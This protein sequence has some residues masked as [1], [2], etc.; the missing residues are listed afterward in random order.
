MKNILFV[1]LSAAIL[2]GCKPSTSAPVQTQ[3]SMTPPVEIN[4]QAATPTSYRY[5]L[6]EQNE[7][8]AP[9]PANIHVGHCPSPGAVQYPLVN[10]V[11]GKSTS[12]LDVSMEDILASA[13]ELSVNVHKSAAESK[14]YTAC[15]DIQ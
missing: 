4:N 8:T 3:P 11:N 9:Q 15:A 1:A 6:T 10:V 12:E 13:P 14:V 5:D 7:F 2:S